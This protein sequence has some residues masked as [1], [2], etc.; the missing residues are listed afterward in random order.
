MREYLQRL[1]STEGVLICNRQEVIVSKTDLMELGMPVSFHRI[2]R[3]IFGDDVDFETFKKYIGF[4]SHCKYVEVPKS[5]PRLYT[6]SLK[7]RHCTEVV[8]RE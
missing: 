2:E 1:C 3:L 4:I 8:R 5:I 7:F 6:Y